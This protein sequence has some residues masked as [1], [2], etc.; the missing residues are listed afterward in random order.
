MYFSNKLYLI[1]LFSTCLSNP[2]CGWCDDGLE[3]GLG[4]CHEG[5]GKGP[6]Q[7]KKNQVCNF[8]NIHNYVALT[9][10]FEISFFFVIKV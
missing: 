10:E 6:L 3:T 7:R 9:T 2:A 8:V 5:G 1:L 4:R